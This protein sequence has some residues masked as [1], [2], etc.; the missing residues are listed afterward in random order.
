MLV[1]IGSGSLRD[2]N[3]ISSNSQ[4]M[5]TSKI[6]TKGTMSAGFLPIIQSVTRTPTLINPQQLNWIFLIVSL[7]VWGMYVTDIAVALYPNQPVNPG[8]T[9]NYGIIVTPLE[10]ATARDR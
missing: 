1:S 8:L 4:N 7:T 3:A 2:K 5:S 10:M 6:T 9:L